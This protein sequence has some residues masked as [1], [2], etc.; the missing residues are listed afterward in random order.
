MR[1]VPSFEIF[2]GALVGLAL[3]GALAAGLLSFGVFRLEG[4]TGAALHYAGVCALAAAMA[5]VPKWRAA[6][7]PVWATVLLMVV[8][9][10]VLRRWLTVWLNLQLIEWRSGPAGVSVGVVLP[11]EGCVLGA[12]LGTDAS[13]RE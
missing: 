13:P 10:F 3:G 9:T 12:V 11:L 5:A 7:R 6:G 1:R 2:F 8:L 4:T